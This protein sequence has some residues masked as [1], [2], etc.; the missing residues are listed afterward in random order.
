MCVS[1]HSV[2]EDVKQEVFVSRP[3]SMPACC[4]IALSLAVTFALDIRYED[5]GASES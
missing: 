2:P 3:C 1:L 4:V 5:K